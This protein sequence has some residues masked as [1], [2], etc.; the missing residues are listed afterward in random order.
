M[1]QYKISH[2]ISGFISRQLEIATSL[3]QLLNWILIQIRKKCLCVTIAL[4]IIMMWQVSLSGI[5]PHIHLWTYPVRTRL[6]T[7]NASHSLAESG[8]IPIYKEFNK[9]FKLQYYI[10]LC[11]LLLYMD[12]AHNA[13]YQRLY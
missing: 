3:I 6:N 9:S 13:L 12:S 7:C 8:Q 1:S 5:V 2:L 11:C 10:P 4:Q